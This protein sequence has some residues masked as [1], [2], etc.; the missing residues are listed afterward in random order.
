MGTYILSAFSASALSPLKNAC[1]PALNLVNITTF[2]VISR[3][4]AALCYLGRQAVGQGLPLSLHYLIII[5]II[6]DVDQG[7]NTS[8]MG[9]TSA[10]SQYL[11]FAVHCASQLFPLA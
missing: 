8:F 9:S 11:L 1:F 6:W 7:V 10:T 3:P 5:G 4:T 2:S